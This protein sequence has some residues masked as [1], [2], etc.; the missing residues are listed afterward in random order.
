DLGLLCLPLV[1][2]VQ[3]QALERVPPMVPKTAGQKLGE[4]DFPAEPADVLESADA[5][6]RVD[7]KVPLLAD[8][9]LRLDEEVIIPVRQR[10]PPRDAQL[11][12]S[13]KVGGLAAHQP[14]ETEQRADGG[15]DQEPAERRTLPAHYKEALK[16]HTQDGAPAEQ[17]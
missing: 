4:H 8:V 1:L 10:V 17:R 7:D 12:R 9:R 5:Q 2:R 6:A 3:D 11:R 13:L 16:E 14:H 15:E